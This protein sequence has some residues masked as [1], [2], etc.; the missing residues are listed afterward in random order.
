MNYRAGTDKELTLEDGSVLASGR[1][2]GEL[3]KGLDGATGLDD[4]GASALGNT[5]GSNVQLGDGGEANVV[6]DGA[7]NN[8]GLAGGGCCKTEETKVIA[9]KLLNSN[10]IGVDATTSQNTEQGT[11]RVTR[12]SDKGGRLMREVKRRRRM[13]LANL[14]PV[15]W[16]RNLYNL[17]RI[18]MYGSVDLTVVRPLA[19]S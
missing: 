12:E 15:R 16:A 9:M 8:N 18:R 19:R 13:V 14:V 17:T 3:V 5:E 7:N 11:Y 2:D 1:G 4:T 6:G 10:R